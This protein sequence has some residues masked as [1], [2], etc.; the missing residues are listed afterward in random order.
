MKLYS[1]FDIARP[2][3]KVFAVTSDLSRNPGWQGGMRSVQP[4]DE[5]HSRVVA[6][7]EGQPGGFFGL[8][9]SLLQ[10]MAERSVRADYARLRE[11]LER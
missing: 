4:I 1:T 7:I 10:H 11:L 3:D 6:D 9:G 8:L 2:A 5:T